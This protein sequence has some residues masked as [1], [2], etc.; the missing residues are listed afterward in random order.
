[1]IENQLLQSWAG[2][3][4]SRFLVEDPL[5][6][7]LGTI[8]PVLSCAVR[9]SGEPCAHPVGEKAARLVAIDA[10]VRIEEW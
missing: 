3:R 4:R 9:S 7:D 6:D 2:V 1:M 5:H 10:F 8:V